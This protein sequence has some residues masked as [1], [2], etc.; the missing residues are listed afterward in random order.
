[1]D[2]AFAVGGVKSFADLYAIGNRLVHRQGTG[3]LLSVDVLHH[4]VAAAVVLTDV[5]QGADIWM[6]QC[7]DRAR[8]PLEPLGEGPL[9]RLDRYVAI[10]PS[11][12]GAIHVAHSSGASRLRDFVRSETHSADQSHEA[13]IIRC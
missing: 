10:E 5:V 2:D 9:D 13:A 1:M 6:V 8:F 11:V 12:V 3:D 4:E 7:R